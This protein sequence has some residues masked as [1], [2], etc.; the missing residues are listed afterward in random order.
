V[1]KALSGLL[2]SAML[3]YRK[4]RDD[5]IEQDFEINPFDHGV[6][7]KMHGD[8]QLTVCWYV[9]DLK[10]SRQDSQVIDDFIQWLNKNNLERS[11]SLR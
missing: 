2:I 4:L 1:T 6:A 5:L 11:E 10:A 3:F 7:N 8:M 9:D